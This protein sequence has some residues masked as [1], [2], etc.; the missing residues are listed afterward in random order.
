V[1]VLIVSKR[2]YPDI[3]GGGEISAYYIAQSLHNLGCDVF[4]LTTSEEKNTLENINGIRI[5][6]I[7]RRHLP[8]LKEISNHEFLY[9]HMLYHANKLIKHIKPD[10][11]HALNLESI[12]ASSASAM[13]NGLPFF[14]TINGPWLTCFTREH[15]DYE[16]KTCLKCSP[17][18]MLNC[19]TKRKEKSSKINTLLRTLRWYYGVFHMKE[20]K[21]YASKADKLFPV[22]NAIKT[23]LINAGYDESKIKVIHNPISKKKKINT[24]LKEKLGINDKK[25]VLYA[26]RLVESKGVQN[27]IKAMKFINNAVFLVLGKGYY[28]DELRKIAKKEKV[29]NKV[30]FLGFINNEKISEFYS[31]ADVV[32]LTGLFYEPLSRMLLEA[33]S[34]GVPMIAGDVGGNSE[35]VEHFKNG[36]LLNTFEPEVI[37]ESIKYIIENDKVKKDMSLYCRKKIKEF[38]PE[39]VGKEIIKEYEKAIT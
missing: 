15:I 35:I 29:E 7:K 22:S 24:S 9:M 11:I 19:V 21:F 14:A 4:V 5:F 1:K 12:P 16:G 28:E 3:K 13:L 27:V 25:V 10:V 2:F 34:Y 39:K 18:K 36:I 26:G 8:I 17:K 31:I 30:K 38:S 32:V 6:R 20:L 37:A 23:L 33:C